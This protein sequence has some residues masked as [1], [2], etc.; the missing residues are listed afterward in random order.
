[1][2]SL[3]P[4]ICL[5]TALISALFSFEYLNYKNYVPLFYIPAFFACIP[6]ILFNAR[7]IHYSKIIHFF[8]IACLDYI[9]LLDTFAMLAT[10]PL[11]YNV[12]TIMLFSN[13]V[14]S[15][16]PGSSANYTYE[17]LKVFDILMSCSILLFFHSPSS[18]F[19]TFSV[20]IKTLRIIFND[21]LLSITVPSVITR[22]FTVFIIMLLDA[23]F[24]TN[25][26]YL[27]FS[28]AR[29]IMMNKKT[30]G[31]LVFLVVGCAS[32]LSLGIL[33][34]SVQKFKKVY[35]VVYF[36]LFIASVILLAIDYRTLPIWNYNK[37][38]NFI[39]MVPCV[40]F[41]LVYS[42]ILGFLE[43]IPERDDA[44]LGAGVSN[45][46]GTRNDAVYSGSNAE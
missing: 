44:N 36:E 29:G 30:L 39:L 7:H 42:S 28:F 33:I 8:P 35:F 10:F 38:T 23:L 4:S 15:K 17:L 21:M 46:D 16:R 41:V 24:R 13:R 6:L 40:V 20:G 3:L 32:Y 12:I 34:N 18:N 31:D 25:I 26:L 9:F 22:I 45:R 19:S 5:S 43:R 37:Y 1:M 2:T 14:L 27:E 11:V